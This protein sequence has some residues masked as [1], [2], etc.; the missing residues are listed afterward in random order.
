MPTIKI[1]AKFIKRFIG[2]KSGGVYNCVIPK[3]PNRINFQQSM[4]T[5]KVPAQFIKRFIGMKSG[6]VYNCLIPKT[7]NRINFQ[8]SMPTIK[9][10]AQ[11][12]K[13]FIRMQ[14]GGVYDCHGALN[15]AEIESLARFAVQ[16]FNKKENALLE[17]A[18][19]LKV[20]EQVV[21]GM[22]YYLTLEAMDAGKK[23]I[24]EAEVWVMPWMNFQELQKFKHA[25]D[26]P[27]FASSDLGAKQGRTR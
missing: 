22:M 3:T 18:R 13:R 4:P 5:I 23:K 21:A 12:I 26:G 17:F 15:S 24:Y 27:S 19:V 8:Q 7:T 14:C 20:R 9:V 10:P 6:G 11:F 25:G 1:P 2:M 16:E